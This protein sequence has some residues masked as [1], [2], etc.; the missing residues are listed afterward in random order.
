MTC[1]N[2]WQLLPL[3]FGLTL[4]GCNNG[5]STGKSNDNAINDVKPVTFALERINSTTFTLTVDGA[6]WCESAANT[7]LGLLDFTDLKCRYSLYMNGDRISFNEV[8]PVQPSYFTVE[9]IGKAIVA[10]LR[11]ASVNS[12]YSYFNLEGTL[13]LTVDSVNNYMKKVNTP[14]PLLDNT[15]YTIASGKETI[16]F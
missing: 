6:D 9:H 11:D 8:I 13:A 2:Q 14:N 7:A 5:L 16:T 15:I 10:K 3:L 4:F 12:G 1:R